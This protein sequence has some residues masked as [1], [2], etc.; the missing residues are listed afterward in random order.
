MV[1]LVTAVNSIESV[2]HCPSYSYTMHNNHSECEPHLSHHGYADEVCITES[3]SDTCMLETDGNEICWNAIL[4][5]ADLN[6]LVDPV[7]YTG[8]VMHTTE[9]SLTVSDSTTTTAQLTAVE[10]HSL[11]LVTS[12]S[13]ITHVI[14]DSELFHNGVTP[15]I[16]CLAINHRSNVGS[17][18]ISATHNVVTCVNPTNVSTNEWNSWP[19]FSAVTAH[20]SQNSAADLLIRQISGNCESIV[21]EIVSPS[22]PIAYITTTSTT[23]TARPSSGPKLSNCVNNQQNI[24]SNSGSSTQPSSP[25]SGNFE[26]TNSL[27][28]WAECKAAL[29]A[30]ALDLESFGNLDAVHNY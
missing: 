14:E 23:I 20:D 9:P 24:N 10:P 26:N 21:S 15:H 8:P 6:E 27:Q 22:P 11:H 29:E 28:P 25:N 5:D 2:G 3:A 19:T 18:V 7:S 17:D 1:E 4:T 12:A 16:N 13:P 30:A